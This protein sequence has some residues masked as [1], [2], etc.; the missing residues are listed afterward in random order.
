MSRKRRTSGRRLDNKYA[1]L[2]W[3]YRGSA[4]LLAMLVSVFFYQ[5]RVGYAICVTLVALV[6]VP[7]A[8]IVLIFRPRICGPCRKSSAHTF[9]L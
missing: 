8:P 5:D 6:I 2:G 4:I 7:L 9:T 3:W 1:F